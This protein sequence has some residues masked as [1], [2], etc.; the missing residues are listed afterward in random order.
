MELIRKHEDEVKRLIRFC[1]VGAVNTLVDFAV[2]ALVLRLVPWKYNHL[3]GQAL[4]F[5]AG[6]VNAYFMNGGWVFRDRDGGRKKGGK[7][8]LRTFAGYAVTF[9]L[10]EGLLMLWVDALGMNKYLAKLINLC[11]TVPSNY[12]INRLWT[13]REE[14]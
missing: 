9:L 6:T 13:F 8:L 7:V 1:I 2:Y 3:L 14:K 10:S 12:V 11:V 4:G 5:V